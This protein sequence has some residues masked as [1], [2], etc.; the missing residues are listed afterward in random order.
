MHLAIIHEQTAVIKQLIDVVVSIPSPQIINI[1]NNLQQ[2]RG[3]QDGCFSWGRAEGRVSPIWGLHLHP[4][5]GGCCRP[6]LRL[7]VRGAGGRAGMGPALVTGASVPQTPLHLAVITK[8]PQ[9]VQLLLQ[10][11][12][13]PTL[14]DRYG[15]SLLHLA[16]HTGDEEMVRTLLTHLGAAAPYLLR[17]PNFYGE[18]GW[19][20]KG[21]GG[22]GARRGWG[23]AEP[24]PLPQA[25]CPCTWP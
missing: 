15:N 7:C 22:E 12:A 2:V 1:T 16:L 19:E 17:L 14:L 18:R 20:T 23:G 11:R 21:P 9:V 3:S 24:L 5:A 4:G 8:Q 10:A 13:D 6:L 25:S